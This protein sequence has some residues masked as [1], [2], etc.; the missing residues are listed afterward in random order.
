MRAWVLGEFLVVLI[1]SGCGHHTASS[2]IDRAAAQGLSDSFM[3]NLIAHRT[4]DAFDEMEPEF[5]KMVNRPDFAP[6][7][8]KLFQYC[9]WPLDSELKR[10]ESGIKVYADGHRNPTRKFTYSATTNQYSKG[11]CYFSIEVAPS[12][13]SLKVTTVGPLKA[14][15]GNPFP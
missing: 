1:L 14:T 8:E 6:Q 4:D 13:A 9:G 7:L 11:V 12:G 2:S 5:T 3:T 10:V 15:S